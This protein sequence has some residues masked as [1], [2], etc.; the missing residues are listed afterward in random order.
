MNLRILVPEATTNYITNPSMKFGTTGW[1]V[2]PGTVTLTR[3]FD[4]ARFGFSS[5]FVSIEDNQALQGTYYRIS[6]LSGIKSPVTASVYIRGGSTSDPIS[7][8][9]RPPRLRLRLIDNPTGK[10]WYSKTVIPSQNRWT[11]LSIS[12]FSTGSDDI[13]MYVEAV[14]SPYVGTLTGAFVFYLDG[15]QLELKPYATTYCD[16]DQPGCKWNLIAHDSISTRDGFTRAGGKWVP[17]AGPCRPNNDI[18]VT[19][20]G[21]FGMA[22][23]VNN[24]QPW[25]NA[26]GSFFQNVK[27]LDRVVTLSF[28]AKHEN[29]RLLG[30]PKLDHLYELRQQLIDIIKP[31]RTAGGEAFLFEYDDGE[32]P[33]YMRFRYE[34]GLEGEWDVRNEWV[35]SFPLRLLAVDPFW[36]EDNQNVADLDFSET[37]SNGATEKNAYQRVN[38]IWSSMPTPSTQYLNDVV[39]CMAIGPKGEVYAG[40]AF[41]GTFGYASIAKWDG[42]QWNPLSNGLAN[43]AVNGIAVAP[44]G[45]LYAVGFFTSIG[46]VAANRVAK[47]NPVTNTWSALSTG[48]NDVGRA[49]CVAPNGQVYIGG[50]FTTAGGVTTNRITRWD[51]TQFRTVGAPTGL[52]NSVRVIVNAG[53]GQTLYIGGDFTATGSGTSTFRRIASVDL[54]TNLISVS[55]FGNGFNN[56]VYALA[57]GRDGTL[58]AAGAF[59]AEGLAPSG[60]RLRIASVFGGNTHQL[61]DGF[62]DGIVY[63]LS[64]APDGSLYAV[65]TFTL[66]GTLPLAKIAKWEKGKF[67][68]VDFIPNKISTTSAPILYTVVAHPNGNIYTG[69]DAIYGASYISGITS[70]TNEGTAE[71][72]PTVYV[73][74]PGILR[75]LEN[76]TTKKR[77]YF[78]LTLLSGEEVFIDFAK[79]SITSNM[80][81]NLTRYV[82]NGSDFK[83]FSLIPGSN[84]IAAFMTDD[85]NGTMK[86]TYTPVHW[87]ADA[88]IEAEELT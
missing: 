69:G 31:D 38:G 86:I 58:Y 4:Q 19:V 30:A 79:A 28:N 21:G 13:R 75:F 61:G 57:V 76:W 46:G 24:I 25:A 51:G 47:Y 40:G 55:I 34:A 74:G 82:L 56:S 84:Q 64:F 70:V 68:P 48:L 73:S 1:S 65:G 16:G 32:R 77:V 12:G 2:T 62:A 14:D 33:L 18:Y 72:Q 50:D 26:P 23:M 22:P 27:V 53:D 10:E 63:G 11:R 80:R 45:T 37:I 17:L 5:M 20:L 67:L 43:G 41:S 29:F 44:D 71:V 42:V 59:T 6:S 66:S 3:S 60:A 85:V 78:N 83:S 8:R 7:P 49:V 81:G 87:S 36:V 88:V 15:A 35:N 52:N 39:S 9:P 54:T